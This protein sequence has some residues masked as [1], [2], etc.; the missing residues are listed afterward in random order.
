MES[1]TETDTQLEDTTPKRIQADASSGYR[2]RLLFVG[3]L[4]LVFS[5]WFLY[6]GFVAYPKDV[7][8]H[9]EYQKFVE[10]NRTAEWPD[11]ARERDWPD[12]S[13]GQPGGN[14]SDS[15]IFLQR[16][17]GF[18]I[19][20]AGL[21]FAISGMRTFG[22]W[23]AYDPEQGLVTNTGQVIPLDAIM[24]LN[25]DRWQKKGIVIVHYQLNNQ[26]GS[27]I[28][29]DWK[30]DEKETEQILRVLEAHLGIE[31]S[32]DSEGGTDDETTSSEEDGDAE[33]ASKDV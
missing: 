19:L 23:I 3:A 25:K 22:K 7:Q 26:G 14:H 31:A 10:E 32:E 27:L 28:L 15:D 12:G 24:K 6:D 8:I 13:T 18:V 30:Y 1:Q 33:P 4:A 21:L 2:Y 5:G 9:N 16:A 20:P 11:Y 29:D 17:L